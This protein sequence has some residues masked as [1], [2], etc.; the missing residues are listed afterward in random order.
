MMRSQKTRRDF[1]VSTKGW[2]GRN[3][4]HSRV[5]PAPARDIVKKIA[6]RINNLLLEE[7]RAESGWLLFDIKPRQLAVGENLI[8][9]RVKDRD[10]GIKPLVIEKLE[11]SVQYR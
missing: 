11:L 10:S 2:R 6:L 1:D 9:V 4:V 8:G 3:R 7:P 5:V